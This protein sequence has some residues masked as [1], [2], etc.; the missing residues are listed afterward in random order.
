MKVTLVAIAYIEK[1]NHQL[2]AKNWKNAIF[3]L[4]KCTYFAELESE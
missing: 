3:V 2:I 4:V 1:D